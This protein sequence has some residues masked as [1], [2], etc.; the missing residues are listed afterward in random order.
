[1]EDKILDYLDGK[2]EYK[3]FQKEFEDFLSKLFIEYF[4]NATHHASSKKED[5]YN[6]ISF[7]S[8]LSRMGQ[9][10]VIPI[11]YQFI[12]SSNNTQST[13]NA[14]KIRLT[15]KLDSQLTN[16]I[17]EIRQ[18][19]VENGNYDENTFSFIYEGNFGRMSSVMQMINNRSI[20]NLKFIK[21]FTTHSFIFDEDFKIDKSMYTSDSPDLS[22]I[23]PIMK[24]EKN[25]T[26]D[27]SCDR[28][29]GYP[30]E[31]SKAKN[32][33]LY[34]FG[35]NGLNGK[36]GLPGYNGGN[37]FIITNEVAGFEK[38]IIRTNEGQGGPGQNGNIFKL[39][40]IVPIF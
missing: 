22:I 6:E 31:T 34:A 36:P 19:Y 23:S 10:F 9:D 38:L 24:V 15:N 32:G 40:K 16:L 13:L 29:P 18:Y 33:Y 30:D 17:N 4:V 5:C 26:I 1:M 27:L 11:D 21:I 8:L 37:L 3:E 12:I 35:S 2:G 25:A 14:N 28:V 7:V 39:R 20:K